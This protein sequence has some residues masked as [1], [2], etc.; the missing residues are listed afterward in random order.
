MKRFLALYLPIAALLALVT[1]VVG[2]VIADSELDTEKASHSA[3]LLN[4][5]E[6]LIEALTEPLN[7]L[8]GILREPAVNRAFTVSANEATAVMGERLLAVMY[9]D[10]IY[11]HVRWVDSHGMELV[12]VDRRGD[13]PVPVA[14]SDLKNMSAHYSYKASI[15]LKPGELYQSNLD[16]NVENG[17]VEV[18]HKPTIRMAIRLPVVDGRD[19]GIIMVNLNVQHIFND[20]RRNLMPGGGIKNYMLL[21]PAGYW[22]MTPN[23]EDAW[24]FMFGRNATLARSNPAEWAQISA[25]KTGQIM[26]SS[27]LWSWTTINPGM[28][29]TGSVKSAEQWKLVTH[30]TSQEI[31]LLQWQQWRFLLIVT[32]VSLLLLG[33][34]VYFYNKLLLEKMQSDNELK[35]VKVNRAVEDKLSL[36]LTAAR[37]GAFHWNVAS[38][39]FSWTD[40]FRNIFGISQE[41]E[42][43]YDNWL[44]LLH[45]EDREAAALQVH[46]AMENRSEYDAEYR[47]LLSDHSVRWIAAKGR[48]YYG[49]DGSPQLMECVASDITEQKRNEIEIHRLNSDLEQRI[50]ERTEKLRESE[51]K[52]RSI[53][54]YANDAII[55]MDDLARIT[56]WNPAAEKIFWYSSTEALGNTLHDLLAPKRYHN[57]FNMGYPGF[58]RTGEGSAMGKSRD[59]FAIRKDG[60][61]IA[62]SVS[63]SAVFLNDA[64][65]A[66]GIVHDIQ[67]R[68]IYEKELEEAR[69]AAETANKAKSEFLSNMSHEIRTPMNGII[70]MMQLMEYTSLDEEQRE[71]VDAIN[72]SSHNLLRLINDIL[73]LSKIEAGKI[74]LEQ[75]EFSFRATVSDVVNTQISLVH[76]KGLQLITDI[77]DEI[78]DNLIGDQLRLKQIILNF[79]S[80]AIKFTDSGSIAIAV[81]MHQ[82]A[83]SLT[84]IRIGVTDSGIGISVGAI[85][86]IFEPFSQ[87]DSSTTRKFGGTGLGLTICRQLAELM[88]GKI[89][90]ESTAGVGS[91]FSVVVPFVVSSVSV[92]H[93][94]KRNRETSHLKWEGRSL[95]I[96]VVD[97]NEIN[98]NIAGYLLKKAGIDYVLASDG[99]EALDVWLEFTFDLILMDVHMPVMNGIEATKIIRE[100]EAGMDIYTPIIAL[101]ADALREE[102]EN[103]LKQGFDGCV[104]KPFEI[105]TLFAEMRRCIPDGDSIAL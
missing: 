57:D 7:H 24:G 42:P 68:L 79:L 89:E 74:E 12:R 65:H 26:L 60:Q 76:R 43:G 9:H 103:F 32:V 21:N 29:K 59:L 15:R 58:L 39:V 11:D 75:H 56:Y 97:D 50:E 28:L 62:V 34:G 85:Q 70:G 31:A 88:G 41:L 33:V 47:I 19:Q 105:N 35:L 23:A 73:D 77:P 99:Q 94:E 98:Q 18:P 48:F 95:R 83:D 6:I 63:S 102:K 44:S 49:E 67:E 81:T 96:L 84:T 87:A 10:P 37:L 91:T 71:Y 27:G 90:V 14:S 101:T 46:H 38:G 45:P 30:T 52:L 54:D 4:G 40:E 82:E 72:S 78:P 51:Q 92:K 3:Q 61:E 25:H 80:N 22:L 1:L 13:D 69:G 36:A 86:K 100:K 104:T 2:F 66:I 5:T 16:L 53:S 64:W 93:Q 55:M 8:R 17:V 20:L